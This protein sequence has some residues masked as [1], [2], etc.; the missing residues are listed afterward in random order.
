MELTVGR[1]RN[2][3]RKYIIEY[4]FFLCDIGR[5]RYDQAEYIKKLCIS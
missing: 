4:R 3:K 1:H 2:H 5:V